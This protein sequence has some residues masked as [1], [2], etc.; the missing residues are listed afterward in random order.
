[1]AIARHLDEL[2]VVGF[3]EGGWPGA[4]PKEPELFRRPQT[5]LSLRR[6]AEGPRVCPPR[7]EG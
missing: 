5:E 4:N 7:R 3:I 1:M 6:A 2:R